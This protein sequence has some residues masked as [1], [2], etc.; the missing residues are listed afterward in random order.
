ME[1][2]RRAHL[3]SKDM[4][5]Q[6]LAFKVQALFS[7]SHQEMNFKDSIAFAGMMS[8]L[9]CFKHIFIAKP[10]LDGEHKPA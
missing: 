7:L 4:R 9:Y 3:H 10:N 2:L 5:H 1:A 8:S 6:C